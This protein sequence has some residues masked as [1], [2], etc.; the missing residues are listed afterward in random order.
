MSRKLIGIV[1]SREIF[2]KNLSN[3]ISLE[4]DVSLGFEVCYSLELERKLHP[5]MAIHLL[6]YQILVQEAVKD[7]HLLKFDSFTRGTP[8]SSSMTSTRKTCTSKPPASF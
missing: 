7:P 1:N 3:R 5:T 6:S 2:L 8:S 4:L